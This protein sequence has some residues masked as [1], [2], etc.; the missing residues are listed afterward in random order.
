MLAQYSRHKVIAGLIAQQQEAFAPD[1]LT[2]D[3]GL[4]RFDKLAACLE[5]ETRS[6]IA[7]LRSMRLTQQS[8]IRSDKAVHAQGK[9]RKPWQIGDD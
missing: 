1:W 7:L 6:M 9:D 2:T 3:D 8:L 5:R 4:K